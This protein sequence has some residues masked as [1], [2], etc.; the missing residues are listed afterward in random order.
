MPGFAFA[1]YKGN[2]RLAGLTTWLRFLGRQRARP[3]LRVYREEPVYTAP[4]PATVPPSSDLDEH[5]E[6]KL[7]AVLE[8]V[9]RYG[10]GSLTEHERQILMR[11]SEVYKKRRT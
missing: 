7:D 9:A 6:A 10:Q 8:K 11:A 2:W 5:L 3:Q 1:Y 4:S